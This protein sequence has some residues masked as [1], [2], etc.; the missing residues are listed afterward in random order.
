MRQVSEQVYRTVGQKMKESWSVLGAS[1]IY[2]IDLALTVYYFQTSYHEE[3]MISLRHVVTLVLSH[4]AIAQ[5]N[6]GVMHYGLQSQE[7]QWV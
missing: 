6:L 1:R 5:S 7:K 2:H 4:S 3:L